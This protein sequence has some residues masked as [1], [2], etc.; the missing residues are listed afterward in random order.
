MPDW[1][2]LA[3][4]PIGRFALALFILGSLRLFIIAVWDI[5][6]AVRKAGDRQIPYQRLLSTTVSW[7]VPLKHLFRSKSWYSYASVG[8]HLGILLIGLFLANHIDL[9]KSI[10][11]LSWPA[12]SKT[13]LDF[14]TGIAILCGIV[15]LLHR[16]YVAESRAL[17]KPMDYL[18]LVLLL[19]IFV[20]G[21]IAGK[22]WNPIPYNSLMLFHA[23]NGIAIVA[24]IPFTKISHCVLFPLIRLGSEVAWHF[25]PRSGQRVVGRNP[26][27]RRQENLIGMLIDVTRCVGCNQCV[28][29]CTQWNGLGENLPQPQSAPDGLSGQRWSSIVQTPE[30]RFVRKLCRH[31]LEP[32][33]VS[34]CPVGAMSKSPEGPVLYDPQICMGCRYC[35]MACPFGIPRYEWQKAV[36]FVQKC[37]FCY[38]RLQV[39][40]L[41]ACKEACPYDVIIVGERSD[42]LKLAHDRISFGAVRYLPTV[43]GETD[44]GGT[45]VLYI[46]DVPLDF[47]RLP[48]HNPVSPE[49]P[50]PSLSASW[51]TKSQSWQWALPP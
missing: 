19:N 38:D 42:L 2:S 20:S 18:L 9:F 36:P 30:G 28:D 8:F 41:P 39:G 29:A 26:R 24:T 27:P 16:L 32:A 51:L 6:S 15:L 14:L 34:A 22:S 37:S 4:G 7:L 21:F 3:T 33:C 47:L 40:Q 5:A 35:M 31:C 23:L 10:T 25:Q 11:G 13:T 46:S 48:V 1:L 45:S 49:N 50:L 43:Y 17:S 44:A 12:I